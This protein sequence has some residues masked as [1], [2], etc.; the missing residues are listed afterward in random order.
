MTIRRKLIEV[1]LPLDVIN[2]ESAR[3]KSIR[4]GHPSTLHLWWARRPLAAARAV[5]FAQL[6]DDPSS[7]PDRFPTDEDQR[8]ERKRLFGILE[9]LV[10][11]E[12]S[13]DDKVLDEARAEILKSCGGQL[14]TIIDPFGG[15]G[16]IPL[17]SARLGLPT[18]TGDLNPVAVLIQR[19]M[20][21][22][23][24]RFAN[25][26]P[27]HPN[28]KAKQTIWSGAEGLA[29]DVEA[30]GQWMREQ[31]FKRI[32]HY[33]PDVTLDDGTQ[34]TPIAWIWARTVKS[35]DPA[36]PSHVPLVRSWELRRRPGKPSIWIQPN[37]D[38]KT[39]TI[40]YTI[41]EGG[42]PPPGT[43]ER[44]RGR[45]L[46]TGT[47]I[48]GDY[49][50][51]EGVADRIGNQLM[52]VVCES[53]HGRRYFSGSDLE[54][55]LIQ[56]PKPPWLPEGAMSDHPQ[57]MGTPRYGIDEWHKIFSTRQLL[58]LTT[59]SD[60][61]T[62]VR[63]R[64]LDNASLSHFE[65]DSTPL[66]DNGAGA[67]AYTEAI[68]T[69]L[70]ITI[71]KSADYW[72]SL[73]TW[74]SNRETIRNTFARQAVSMAWDFL[75]T[76]P[77]SSST[78]NWL[79]M[80]TWVTKAL[81]RLPTQTKCQVSQL[82]AA[83]NLSNQQ[84]AVLSTDPPYYDNVPY[85]DLSDFFYVWIR[86]NLKSIWPDLF[87]T[88]LTPKSEELVANHVRAGSKD[89]ARR[90]FEDGMTR[91]FES[92]AKACD[93][94]Y[95]AAVFYAFKS[96]EESDE[97]LA[98]TGWETFLS[99]VLEAGWSIGATWPIR[100]EMP[101]RTRAIE[102]NALASSVVLSMRRKSKDAPI[103]TRGDFASTL[104]E[105]L[106]RAIS[107]LQEQN[108]APVDLAQASIGPGIAVF[109]RYSRVVEANGENM[110]IR[111][112]LALINEVLAEILSGEE[113]EFDADTRFAVT[114]FE[115]F[116]HSEGDFGVAD[117]LA[118]AK[119]TSVANVVRSGIASSRGGKFQLLRRSELV[120]DWN[121]TDDSALTIWE[122]TH[123]LIRA[124][125]QSEAQAAA[126]LKTVGPG[127]GAQ[128]RQLSYMLYRIAERRR[129][130]DAGTY[131]MLVTAWP[132]L[133][134]LATGEPG[135]TDESLF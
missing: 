67:V 5:V 34:A 85:S 117:I 124:L 134:R 79:S 64:V 109:S 131:N 116:G 75:E 42:K 68:L 35:P 100:T 12:A 27:I 28:A 15:G 13:Y 41:N 62:E 36:W 63:T 70:A 50:K 106:R 26:P 46:A 78:G 120:D 6:V 113:A 90:H 9:R 86:R 21:E 115:Q 16:A 84:S 95:P 87:A 88:V 29:A 111:N 104:R 19:A 56:L 133:Q 107:T 58:A 23:P 51:S 57:Y 47:V 118:R 8:R 33:Y 54:S 122:I 53:S 65:Q 97:G 132:Q 37:V 48:S 40:T 89:A 45:C 30:F 71:D 101:N 17:E 81:Q 82:D 135:T 10:P 1:A 77:F 119:N 80:L 127:L 76:N 123:Y 38:H 105:E 83:A 44:G 73:C 108:I 94:S 2:A 60:L 92:A 112:A 59:F 3:E 61:L 49:I 102:A 103:A 11:W 18:V 7:H 128:A 96:S 52:A 20:L 25:Q 69:Y 55:Q 99:G 129:P 74:G 32:G 125:E 98:S 4:H 43:V 39:K 31:A 110:T 126:L 114:W 24:H 121:P 72:S 130:E 93:P 14:P 66:S 22:I 91:V